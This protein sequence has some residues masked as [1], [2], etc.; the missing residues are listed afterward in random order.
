MCSWICHV[1]GEYETYS[2]AETEVH[3][4][5]KCNCESKKIFVKGIEREDPTSSSVSS[6]KCNGGRQ[7]VQ[8]KETCPFL[9]FLHFSVAQPTTAPSHHIWICYREYFT[10]GIMN[11]FSI[12][13][14][15]LLLLSK[16]YFA[17]PYFTVHLAVIPH[18]QT[19]PLWYLWK[20]LQATKE[21]QFV[22]AV[23][24]CNNYGT[25]FSPFPLAI[26]LKKGDTSLPETSSG[27]VVIPSLTA[28]NPFSMM[29]GAHPN[30]KVNMLPWIF[31]SYRWERSQESTDEIPHAANRGWTCFYT[32]YRTSP[33]AE[34]CSPPFPQD[35]N[36]LWERMNSLPAS[37]VGKTWVFQL[38]R[39]TDGCQESLSSF[40][41][42]I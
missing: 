21:L 25:I 12:A 1:V 30:H 40:Y 5:S 36:Y 42:R 17:A 9:P 3:R 29:T 24:L 19:L 26:A 22:K 35:Y 31:A 16:G 20:W 34:W 8:D 28:W 33:E 13:G 41:Y 11:L 15:F 18:R 27:C 37:T 38:C 14:L 39:A 4:I 6:W 32:D 23:F 2:E 7:R 10:Q